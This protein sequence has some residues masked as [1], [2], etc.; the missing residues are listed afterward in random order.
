MWCAYG[1]RVCV[2]SACVAY[3]CVAWRPRA[4]R[5]ACVRVQVPLCGWDVA[6][7]KDHGMLLLEVRACVR[8]CVRVCVRALLGCVVRCLWLTG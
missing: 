2:A 1:V 5:A 4:W 6:L 7:T 3:V 8:V